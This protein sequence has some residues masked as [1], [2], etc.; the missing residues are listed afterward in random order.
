[1]RKGP[2]QIHAAPDRAP[3][4]SS[5]CEAGNGGSN[6]ECS[7]AGSIAERTLNNLDPG[8]GSAVQ[9]TLIQVAPETPEIWDPYAQQL[10]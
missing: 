10:R 9:T 2:V 7:A 6:T 1:V 5:R 3:I 8:S 4:E